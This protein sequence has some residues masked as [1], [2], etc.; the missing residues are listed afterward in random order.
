[1]LSCLHGL[2]D[3]RIYWK[4]ALSLQ[5]NGYEVI[6][7]GVGDQNRDFISEHGIRLIELSRK[8]YFTNPFLDKAFRTIT[9][10]PNIYKI[11]YGIAAGIRADV[12]HFHDLQ[13]NRIGPKLKSLPHKPN[14]I[15]DVHEPY[16]VTIT[17]TKT[18]WKITALFYALYGNYIRHWESRKVR[19]YDKI[20]ATEEN[21]YERFNNILGEGKSAIIYN[22]TN[23]KPL[24]DE[25]IK[26]EFDLI[27]T[28]SIRSIRGVM[29]ILEAVD[30]LINSGKKLKMLFIGVIHEPDLEKKMKQ[31]VASKV[32]QDHISIQAS[33]P[34]TDITRYYSLSRI[35]LIIFQD[36][37]VNR[38]ILPIKLFEY[39]AFGLPVICSDFGHMVTYVKKE[40][41]G[42]AVDP[43]DPLAISEAIVRLLEDQ[44]FYS[45]CSK[46]GR[47][48]ATQKYSWQIM[49]TRLLRLYNN[50]LKG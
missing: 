2:F 45:E 12:Y 21:V 23:L 10:R 17:N 6:H 13:L 16:P 49:E 31:F 15:Y 36:L 24:P 22:Y 4:E 26:K 5:N 50:L 28:G 3:D 1:M 14:V 11:L 19:H 40:K 20:I 46:N 41:C 47:N 32:L 48:A 37:P 44:E 34:Y 38:T 7:I 8:R 33:V 39:M 9:F 27:Y 18:R 30:I 43:S 42:I 29:Q 25:G 35:G